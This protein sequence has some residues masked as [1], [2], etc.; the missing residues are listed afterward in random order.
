MR[1]EA[2]RITSVHAPGALLQIPVCPQRAC[3]VFQ[4]PSESALLDVAA[5]CDRCPVPGAR[6]SG[7]DLALCAGSSCTIV[8]CAPV[9]ACNQQYCGLQGRQVH[10]AGLFHVQVLI[11]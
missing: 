2:N 4:K 1:L 11:G 3:H 9:A 10:Q 8:S 5:A 6:L 7:A